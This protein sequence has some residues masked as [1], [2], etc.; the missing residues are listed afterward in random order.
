MIVRE[1]KLGHRLAAMP[2]RCFYPLAALAVIAGAVVWGAWLSLGLA[3]LLWRAIGR[4][5]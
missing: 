2:V 5:A 1:R 4:W 3:F